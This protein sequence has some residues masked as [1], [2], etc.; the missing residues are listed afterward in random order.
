MSVLDEAALSS[1][2]VSPLPIKQ[3]VGWAPDQEWPFWSTE[4]YITSI[5]N[6]TTINR[7]WNARTGRPRLPGK[8]FEKRNNASMVCKGTVLRTGQSEIRFPVEAWDFTHVK[9]GQTSS[10]GTPST[11]TQRESSNFPGVQLRGRNVDYSLHYSTEIK[12]KRN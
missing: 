3:K 2:T 10:G 8:F 7:L 9:K 11:P 1:G 12:N 6:Q 4:Q 5:D